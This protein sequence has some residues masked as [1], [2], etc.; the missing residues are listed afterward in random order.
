M[1]AHFFESPD[2]ERMVPIVWHAKDFMV[3]VSGDPLRNNAYVFSH[4]AFMGYPTGKKVQL[5]KDWDTL[6][7]E[8]KKS[9]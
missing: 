4:N 8:S 3:C 1:P 9:G 5:P 6:L 7:E 2:P